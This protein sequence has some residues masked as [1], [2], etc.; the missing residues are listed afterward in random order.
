[1]VKRTLVGRCFVT[2]PSLP[3]AATLKPTLKENSLPVTSSCSTAD[4]Q[5]SPPAGGLLPA[6]L[7]PISDQT[8]QN[9]N[10]DFTRRHS[11]SLVNRIPPENS[12]AAEILGTL[13]HRPDM[14][15]TQ[16]LM[17]ELKECILHFGS[18]VS[19]QSES[20]EDILMSLGMN[21]QLKVFMKL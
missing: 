17:N 14:N 10:S 1:M 12:L 15:R 5:G 3:P 9:V 2:L 4:S 18:C 19:E 21:M 13:T 8:N 6:L 20:S 11:L 7:S 16:T